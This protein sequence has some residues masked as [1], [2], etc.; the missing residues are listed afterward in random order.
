VIAIMLGMVA[1]VLLAGHDATASGAQLTGLAEPPSV[2]LL[3][4]LSELSMLCSARR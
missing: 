2:S 1:V 4:S 3:G